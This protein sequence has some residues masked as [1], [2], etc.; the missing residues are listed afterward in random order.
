MPGSRANVRTSASAACDAVGACDSG[1]SASVSAMLTTCNAAATKNG[2]ANPK[3]ASAPLAIGPAM[4]PRPNAAVPKASACGRSALGRHVGEIRVCDAE[5]AAAEPLDRARKEEHRQAARER[6]QHVAG[7]RRDL[8]SD[9]RAFAAESIARGAP[10]RRCDRRAERRRGEQRTRDDVGRSETLGDEGQ[11]RYENRESDDVEKGDPVER[12][13][14]PWE[15]GRQRPP[16]PIP[17]HR[18]TIETSA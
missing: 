7:E 9:E 13:Q 14:A 6:E 2:T 18:T 5:V 17:R 11:Q 16:L 8:R 12:D 3:C 4:K 1:S 15:A 10:D